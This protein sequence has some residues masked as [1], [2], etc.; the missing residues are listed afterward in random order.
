[1]LFDVC[2]LNAWMQVVSVLP[3]PS[4]PLIYGQDLLVTIRFST[5]PRGTEEEISRYITLVSVRVSELV[6]N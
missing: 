1:M 3:D 4:T 5:P 2:I 6:K